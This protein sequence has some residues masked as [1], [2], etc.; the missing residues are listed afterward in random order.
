MILNFAFYL[1]IAVLLTGI[2]FLVD[3]LFIKKR[4]PSK[5]KASFLFEYSKA[6]FPVLLIVWIVRSFIIQPYRV[7]TGSLES[8]VMPGDFVTVEQFA[9]GLRFPVINKKILLIGELKRGQIVLF[10][11]SENLTIV[12]VKRV[13]GL[14]GEHIIDKNKELYINGKKQ[15]QKFFYAAN[16]INS[17]RYQRLVY[18]KEEDLNGIKYKI[19]VQPA[20]GETEN[21][22]LV[23]P[24][25]HYFMMG[26][27]RDNSDDSRQWRFVPEKI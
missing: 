16:D 25:R 19:Y 4:R 13:I 20:G 21:Y 12:F 17:W 15:K 3:W 6:F 7:S 9:Y 22:D 27:N 18:V 1:I 23:V 5:T 24:L 2:I 26:D 14:P 11:W 10:P 8:T